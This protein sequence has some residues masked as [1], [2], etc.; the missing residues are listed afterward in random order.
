MRHFG[1]Y[2]PNL[3]ALPG[4]LMTIKI[5]GFPE[6]RKKELDYGNEECL[7]SVSFEYFTCTVEYVRA[8]YPSLRETKAAGLN[9][10]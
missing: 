6:G 8:A 2:A 1:A 5:P 4:I 10:S 3:E 9:Q 7:E